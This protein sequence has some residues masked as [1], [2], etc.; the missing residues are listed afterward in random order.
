[1]EALRLVNQRLIEELEQL[2]GQ[3]QRSRE[4]RQTQEG[5]NFPPHERQ[6]HLD[7]PRGAVTEAESSRAKGHGPQPALGEEGNEATL[8]VQVGNEELHHPQPGVEELSWEQRFKS[9]QQELSRVKEV[10][11]GRA[12]DTMDTL[13]QQTKS[14]FTVEVLHFPLP[15]K[16]RMP[17]VEAF[18][19]VKDPVD[20]LNTYKNQ[21]ELHEYQ[22]PVRCKAFAITLKGPALAWFNRFSPSSISSF[23]E[24][25]IAFVSHFIGARTYRKP[26]RHL[27]TIKQGSQESLRSYV[28]RFN[29]ES[30]KVEIPDE[31]FSITA[32][33]AGLGVQ[34]KDLMFSISKNSQASMAE[35]LEKAKKY[36]NGE[37]ALISKKESSSTHKEKS[38]T[39]KR[40]GRSPKRQSV[41]ETSPRKDRERSPKRRGNLRDLLGPP[42]F[43]RRRRYSP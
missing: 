19:G 14:P 43:E 32:F 8:G 29:A 18:D 26:R 38:G 37:K 12:P 41:R 15:A 31:K 16:F 24:L 4:A 20:H 36:I 5:H 40:R 6:P 27:P 21:M 13:V 35:V 17:Q 11:R 34:S 28:Q 42:Q 33:I 1:M 7:I 10:V 23:R 2:T 30:L 25:S 3:M 39:D 22:D 9:L